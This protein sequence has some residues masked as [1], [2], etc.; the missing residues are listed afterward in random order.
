MK[1]TLLGT[2]FFLVLA[3]AV[4]VS[5]MAGV[6]INLGIALPPPVVFEAPPDVV[7]LPDTSD[8]YV[9]PDSDADIFFWNGWWWRLW[10][11]RW[12]RAHYYNRGW[13]FYSGVPSFYFG[14]DPDWRR[15]YRDHDWRGHR[16]AYERIPERRLQQNWRTW[17]NNR[18]WE[19][20]ATWG[21]EKY[22]RRSRQQLEEMRHQRQELYRQRPEVQR[23]E[24][25][26]R[27]RQR[28]VPGKEA[29]PQVQGRQHREEQRGGHGGDRD[30]EK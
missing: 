25:F 22:E 17:H 30:R 10:E 12:Y 11:G 5:S 1:R 7:V 28:H 20:R 2:I 26:M 24:E 14:V 21:V 8:V 13:A 4:P 27:E 6:N 19:K 23:H 15:Y 18:Y 3:I 29:H 16:W 9:V